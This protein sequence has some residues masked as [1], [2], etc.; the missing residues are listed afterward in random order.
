MYI[1]KSSNY[2]CVNRLMRLLFFLNYFFVVVDRLM[3][4]L[5]GRS[6][7]GRYEDS[8]D[9]F[10]AC[11]FRDKVSLLKDSDNKQSSEPFQ[12]GVRRGSV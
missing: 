11:E 3:K 12:R 1:R 2:F 5:T 6:F 4:L 9:L 8:D 7:L 10:F